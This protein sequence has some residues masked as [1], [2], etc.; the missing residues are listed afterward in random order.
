MKESKYLVAAA[1]ACPPILDLDASVAQACA[2]IDTAGQN[3][4]RLI[5]FPECYLPS[6]PFWVWF[7]P[8]GKTTLL[9]DLYGRLVA[10]S[11]D[12][13]G[14]EVQRLC[15]AARSAGINVAIGLNERNTEASG[16]TLLNSLLFID[17][18]GDILGCHRKLVPTVG[19]R[20]VHGRGDGSTLN[21]YEMADVGRVGGL[22]CW[23]NYMPLARYALFSAGLQLH[24]APTWDR[25]EPW[26]STVRHIAKEGRVY[27]VSCCSAVRR[28]DAIRAAPVLA[29]YL[30]EVEWLNPGGSCIVDP[31]GKF[32]IE[33][34]TNREE[35]IYAEIDTASFTGPRYQL[36]VAGHYSRPDIFEL[37]MDRRA[38][39]VAPLDALLI[40]DAE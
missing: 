24:V 21:V 26:T 28:E 36:D 19:E 9:R 15:A 17:D 13:H 2:L 16:S 25:G 18:N 34:V 22:I 12:R 5:V 27:V 4:A 33:P 31:D 7:V 11:V 3:G 32:I 14:R 20:M 37:R 39:I 38:Q 35:L 23:E 10:N 8:A 29:E 1:Q 6:Y 30:P 40:E